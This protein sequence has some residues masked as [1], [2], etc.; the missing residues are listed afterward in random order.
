MKMHSLGSGFMPPGIHAGG[1][2]YHGMAP[3]VSLMVHQGLARAQ[4]FRQ[5]ECFEAGLTFARAE[6]ILPAPEATH[7]VK[8][9]IDAA[10]HC[11]ATGE[12]KT[13]L[14]NLSGH[15]YFDMQAYIDYNSGK[16]AS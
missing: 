5:L 7:A 1:L 9:A 2:R 11:K 12:D 14:F 8:A 15:G 3:L 10:L 13:I 6:G 16:L 4:S